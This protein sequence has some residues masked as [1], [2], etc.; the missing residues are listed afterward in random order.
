MDQ[1]LP[2]IRDEERESKVRNRK[3]FKQRKGN[4]QGQ[5]LGSGSGGSV[6][7]G[8]LDLDPDP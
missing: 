7:I 5:C 8:L 3:N 1:K 6:I 4:P 2:K